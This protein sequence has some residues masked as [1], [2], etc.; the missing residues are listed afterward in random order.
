M[1]EV[2]LEGRLV[3]APVEYAVPNVRPTLSE[4]QAWCRR[5]ATSHYENFHVATW[6]LPKR[7][8]P[9]FESIYAF[10]RTADDFGDEVAERADAMRLLGEW[11]QMLQECYATPGKAKHPVFVALSRTIEQTGVPMHLF[12]DLI[13]AFETD[14]VVTQHESM[15]SLIAYSRLSANPVGRLVLW[16]GG[17]RDE[18]RGLLSD[19]VCTA[20]QLANFWQDVVE[21]WE[22][23]RRYLPA[24]AMRRFGVTDCMIAER[25]FTP[26]FRAM[27]AH[28]VGYAAE[29]LDEGCQIAAE[30]DAELAV[31]LRLFVEGGRAA[32][33]GI[34][35]QN[36]DVL[37]AR[38]QVSK[39]T[40]ARLLAR[41]LVGK[42]GSVLKR[43]KSTA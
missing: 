30:V 38:P 43:G 33:N 36:F 24:D 34:I 35:A 21:D 42:A 4:A 26:D 15:E 28:L 8:R 6:F 41:A 32:L 23:G 27:M 18:A 19:K 2:V 13:S 3:G 16:V 39:A 1:T 12:D 40:K 31:T 25:Q 11:R 7:L 5:L 20:L 14:Q 17:Y 10:S 37:R 29:M 9:H 22:R